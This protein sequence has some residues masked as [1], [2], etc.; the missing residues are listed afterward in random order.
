MLNRRERRAIAHGKPFSESRHAYQPWYVKDYT[1]N[2]VPT[3]AQ[4]AGQEAAFA[5]EERQRRWALWDKG[6]AEVEHPVKQ[7][8]RLR[9]VR[10]VLRPLTSRLKP[11]GECPA[12]LA[13]SPTTGRL[14]PAVR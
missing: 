5:E 8:V 1:V 3:L 10:G 12:P 7:G 6:I 13:S 9:G 4:G 11:G 2:A 14:A